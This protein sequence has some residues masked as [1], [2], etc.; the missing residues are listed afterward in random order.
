MSPS[1]LETFTHLWIDTDAAQTLVLLHGTGAD[2]HNLV[3][4]AKQIGGT[5]YNILS[6][7]GN[8]NERGMHRFFARESFG[9]FD[10][11]SIDTEVEKLQG[12]LQAFAAEHAQ[13]LESMTFLGFSNG[14][15]MILALLFTHPDLVQ[16]AI[17][18]HPML[19]F[20]P[21]ETLSL[22][23]LQAAVTYSEEDQI[24]PPKQSAA[25]ITALETAGA[26]IETFQHEQGHRLT[27]HEIAFITAFLKSRR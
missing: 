19:P 10:R 23:Q 27:T 17:L 2:E 20:T 16:T 24:I 8:V 3:P 9:V 25:V 13:P 22:Q 5:T 7:R 26:S 1:P 14:A 11:E 6:L 12:F 18:L 4:L 15:N 21:D